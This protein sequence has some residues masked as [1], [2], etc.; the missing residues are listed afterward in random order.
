MPGAEI[1]IPRGPWSKSRL[2]NV[3]RLANQ[4]IERT[5]GNSVWPRNARVM[6]EAVILPALWTQPSRRKPRESLRP[7]N[8]SDARS[9]VNDYRNALS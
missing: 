7:G 3:Q 1:E 5:H 9:M 4:S 6:T 8:G 2:L